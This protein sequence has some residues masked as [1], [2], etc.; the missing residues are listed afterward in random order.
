MRISKDEQ[1][2][3]WLRQN[4]RLEHHEPTHMGGMG[5][6]KA[7]ALIVFWS[8]SNG[9]GRIEF[10]ISVWLGTQSTGM[11]FTRLPRCCPTSATR[12]G[13]Y[14]RR[15]EFLGFHQN[16]MQ[17]ATDSQHVRD[18]GRFHTVPPAFNKCEQK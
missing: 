18:D 15:A 3:S 4:S 16:M 14:L 9:F 2:I 1:A 10:A 12:H 8:S 7:H 13:Y 11:Q 5:R 17:C 6:L